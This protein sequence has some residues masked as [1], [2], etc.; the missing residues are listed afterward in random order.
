MTRLEIYTDGGCRGNQVD[1]NVGGWGALLIWGEHRLELKG[2][3]PNTTNNK[4]ELTGAIEALRAVKNTDVPVD[5]YV[6][7]AYVLNGIT[8]WI[9]GWIKKDWKNSKK[10]PVANKELWLELYAQKKRFSDISFHKVKGHS[11][12]DGN[13]KADELA[14]LA[15]DEVEASLKAR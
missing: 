8:Q 15:M 4:M 5:V 6:D 2:G 12:N 3:E 7:S 1:V 11:T 13:N 14:N 9:Y 10:E